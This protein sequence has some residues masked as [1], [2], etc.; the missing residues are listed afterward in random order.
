MNERL[1]IGYSPLHKQFYI[2][3]RNAG[4]SGFS[5]EFAGVA[6]A[7]YSANINLKLHLLIDASSVELFA[8]EGR[9][10]MTS[11][12]FPTEKFTT[13]KLFSKGGNIQLNKAV[14][15]G[16]ERI[17]Q[18]KK[19]AIIFH[20]ILNFIFNLASR[21]VKPTIRSAHTIDPATTIKGSC[22]CL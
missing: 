3:R 19:R 10:V 22:D 21:A 5:K 2:D 15:Y 7:P 13:L 14:F 9:L 6:S 18:R 8:D 16:I 17:W 12:V 11:L 1:V 20:Q 4:N